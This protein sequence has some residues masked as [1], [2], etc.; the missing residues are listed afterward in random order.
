MA[1]VIK[2]IL[3][4]DKNFTEL[5]KKAFSK[6]DIDGSGQID[7]GE[8]GDLFKQLTKDMGME[9]TEDQ[10]KDIM[11]LMDSDNSGQVDFEEFKNIVR[12]CFEYMLEE[13]F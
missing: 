12:E 6:V 11:E 8:L 10:I 2:T 13:D 5:C 1:K 7:Q 3:N 4:D 9:I